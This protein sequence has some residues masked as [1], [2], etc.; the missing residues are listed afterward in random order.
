MQEELSRV[1]EANLC[2][3]TV[4]ARHIKACWPCVDSAWHVDSLRAHLAGGIG[5]LVLELL[6]HDPLILRTH[7][8]G[9]APLWLT[10]CL[11][12]QFLEWQQFHDSTRHQMQAASATQ[13][14]P[15]F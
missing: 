2:S 10:N 5:Q 12:G 8:S 13:S 7:S 1:T 6:N 11:S 14:V 3:D 9:Q 15:G 4:D